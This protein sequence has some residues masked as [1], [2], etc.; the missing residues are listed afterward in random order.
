MKMT[1]DSI[2]SILAATA[3]AMSHMVG[4]ILFIEEWL[5][6]RFLGIDIREEYFKH[7]N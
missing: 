4:W 6:K 5:Y 2:A 1:I 7:G 3:L